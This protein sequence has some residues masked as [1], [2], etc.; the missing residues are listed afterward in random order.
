MKK[1]FTLAFILIIK[2]AFAQKDT[3]GL[4][5]PYID[6][7]VAYEKVVNTPGKTHTALFNNAMTWLAVQPGGL[8][9]I[10][11]SDSVAHRLVTKQVQLT[12]FDG[13]AGTSVSCKVH[14]ALQIDC[15]DGKYRCRINSILLEC[16]TDA[17]FTAT[18]EELMQQILG[19]KSSPDFNN[20]MAKRA[21]QAV[22]E[23]MSATMASLNKSMN[24]DF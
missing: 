15:R 7:S 1:L 2:T 23:T 21:L 20:N 12:M 3:I 11:L 19:E 18:P 13:P 14:F 9:A 5:V 24:D 4:H 22:N 6:G 8:Q 17:A 10:Q 16:K